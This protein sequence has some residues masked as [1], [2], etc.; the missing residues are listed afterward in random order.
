VLQIT[1]LRVI[2]VIFL[3]LILFWFLITAFGWI[4]CRHIKKRRR[5]Q[6]K[7]KVSQCRI[8]LYCMFLMCA[9]TILCFVLIK[10]WIRGAL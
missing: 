2:A 8:L 9:V 4:D 6:E 7:T 5:R 10:F 3:G 1:I